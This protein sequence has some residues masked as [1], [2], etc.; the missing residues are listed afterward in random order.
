VN[1]QGSNPVKE[2]PGKWSEIKALFAEALEVDP[3]IRASWL[4]NRCRGNPA[5]A[6]ELASL[7]EHDHSNDRF[8]ETP[9]WRLNDQWGAESGPVRK[10][11]GIGPGTIVGSWSVV[12]EI[13]T[14]G[15]GTVYLA[16]RTLDDDDQPVRQRAAIKIIRARMDAKLLAG[17]FRRERRI[18]AQLNHPFIARFLEGGTLENGLPYFALDYVEGEPIDE[19]CRNRQ[20]GLAETLHLFCKV[21]S[22]VAYAHRNLVVHRDLKPSNI[23]VTADRTP[24]LLDF[25][26]AKL[27][28]EEEESSNQTSGVGP[29]TPRYSS[30][31]QIRGEPVT[32]ASDIFAL[33][34]ILYE[35]VFGSHPFDPAKESEPAP[36]IDVLRR[37]CEEEPRSGRVQYRQARSRG[38]DRNFR[39]SIGDLE[40]IILRALQKSPADRYQS[41]EYMID[42][43]QNLLD[44][45]PVLARPQSWWYRARTLIRRHPTATTSTSVAALIGII[46][47][48]F[49]LASDRAMRR[50]RDYALQQRELAASSAQTMINDL[51]STLESM[52]APV[53]RRLELLQRVVGVFD[54]IDATSRNQGTDPARSPVQINAEVRTQLILAR[55][56]EELGDSQGA[57]RRADAAELRMRKLLGRQASNA[58]DR[59]M[60]AEVMLE[61]VR[62]LS[63]AG[64]MATGIEVLEQ[65]L[66]DLRE[67]RNAKDLRLDAERKLELLLCDGLLM[68]VKWNDT[69]DNSEEALKAINEAVQ[70][71]QRAYEA[72]PLDR[73]CF[74]SYVNSLEILGAFFYNSG[75]FNLFREPVRK[76]LALC[77]KAAA[78]SP[79]DVILQKLSERIIARWVSLLA[80]ADSPDAK[81][82]ISTESLAT[83]R[84]LCAADPNNIGLLEELIRELGNYGVFLM[85]Q[86]DFENAKKP[87][88]E[89]LDISKKAIDQKKSS[90][91]AKLCIQNYAFSL[92]HCY[93][94]TGDID[95]ARKTN[96]EFL[97]P[98]TDELKAIDQDESNNRFR[99]A[100]C[101]YAQAEV[102]SSEE[103][104][105][106]A[107]QMF[108]RSAICLEKNRQ[109][110]NYPYESEVYGDCLA[111]LG[112][113]LCQSA[114]PESGCQYIEKGLQI[115][116]GLRVGFGVPA[117]LNDI[118]DAEQTLRRYE[119]D[120]KNTDL[121]ATTGA[122]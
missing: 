28:A 100:L 34:I 74:N 72:C 53:D 7:L 118:S 68:K 86:N 29:C 96:L 15:M 50:E 55:A 27:L 36:A 57:V 79:A 24:R 119:R 117:I 54:R 9:A 40:S 95:A 39:L 58:D 13:C 77:R 47:L 73:E 5:L 33:G 116:Y 14:G 105:S 109:T 108:S 16:E 93:S 107:E 52:A 26:I 56:L 46:A 94:K 88:E 101:W 11:L 87:L 43:I 2:L 103:K 80:F 114:R 35:L 111:R 97:V 102:A 42:D 37:I 51:A 70:Y 85:N 90:Y 69:L 98:L 48:G 67:L 6:S 10:E 75:R 122:H 65:A 25:G 60:L 22:A 44:R 4:G 61:K 20:L 76:A 66:N 8:L 30:P 31:E 120:A 59:L 99:A 106:E 19:Y 82:E 89:A 81:A 112:S 113:V 21:C 104:W 12:D 38:G 45:R 71:G 84:K 49:I 23:L 3:A 17:R 64:E 121:F 91:Y 92:S 63:N 41:V 115:M 32:T 83:M 110:R 18:L 62:A 1:G 78:Q